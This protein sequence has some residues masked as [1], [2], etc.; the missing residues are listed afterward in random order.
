MAIEEKVGP[1]RIVAP[2][3]KGGMGRVYLAKHE[4]KGRLVAIKVLPDEFLKDRKRSHYLERE[5]KIAKKLRHPN[6]VDIYGLHRQNGV[7]YL[8]MEYI[9]GGNLR[10]HIKARDLSLADTLEVILRICEG[11]HYIHNHK[12]EDG[13]FHS[14]IHRDIKPENI[15]LSQNGRIKVADFGL[16]L[17]DESWTLRRSKSRAGTPYYMSPEQIRGRTLDIRTDIY[18]LGLVLY[19]LLTGQLPYKAHSRQMYMKMV[20]SKKPKPAPPSYINKKVSHQ[21]DEITLKALEKK[22]SERYQTIAEMMLDLQRLSPILN[23]DDL[24]EGFRFMQEVK[25][26]DAKRKTVE[27]SPA[28]S[29]GEAAE[30]ASEVTTPAGAD[31]D[32]MSGLGSSESME[33]SGSQSEFELETAELEAMSDD[34]TDNHPPDAVAEVDD[35]PAERITEIEEDE[36][37]EGEL[38]IGAKPAATGE[39][40]LSDESGSTILGE[41]CGVVDAELVSAGMSG[42]APSAG[43]GPE[44]SGDDN[45][46]IYLGE[47]SGDLNSEFA[48][49]ASIFEDTARLSF[50]DDLPLPGD[51]NGSPLDPGTYPDRERGEDEDIIFERLGVEEIENLIF[52]GRKKG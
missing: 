13:R 42:D 10:K 43:S 22:T 39:S 3:A 20:I 29:G 9:D 32:L 6:I 50:E 23:A 25:M 36:T 28:L 38:I 24:A 52:I 14:I 33:S 21:F 51:D 31:A 5:L 4:E 2:I 41:N 49:A 48:E 7:G 35:E 37:P 17:S 46:D 45:G 40:A 15:L 16:S 30:I 26:P 12:L 47:Q 19:E 8:I 27:I 44:P 18:S 34:G 11:L 1:F